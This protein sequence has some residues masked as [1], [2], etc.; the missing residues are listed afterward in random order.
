MSRRT[1]QRGVEE[2]AA[3]EDN[4]PGRVARLAQGGAAT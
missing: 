2:M 4:M 1:V 3:G